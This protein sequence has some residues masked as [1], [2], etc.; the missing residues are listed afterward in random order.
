MVDAFERAYL[1]DLIKQAGGNVSSAA[2]K[3]RL[4]RHHLKDLLKKHGIKTK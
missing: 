2:R 4:D 3:A 1:N